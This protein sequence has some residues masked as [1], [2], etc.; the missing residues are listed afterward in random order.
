MLKRI[1]VLADI[2]KLEVK[3]SLAEI[4]PWLENLATIKG[5]FTKLEELLPEHLHE[6]DYLMTFGG[7]GLLLA[8]ARYVAGTKIP[9]IGVNFGRLGFLTEL[10]FAEFYNQIPRILEGQRIIAPR[11][12]LRCQVERHG[13]VVHSGLAV[14]DAVIKAASVARMTYTT[15]FIDEE[16]IT[17]YGGDGVIIATPVGSTAYSLSAG[18]PIVSPDIPALVITP[19]CPHV[20]TLRPLVISAQHRIRIQFLPATAEA[21][22]ISLD[23]QINWPLQLHDQLIITQAE[24]KFYLVETGGRSFYHILQEK[25]TW[26]HVKLNHKNTPT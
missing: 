2:R 1:A 19:I 13:T 11:M 12:M 4:Q 25:L 5:W 15:L 9:L 8:A 24:E 16:E 3:R 7:D 10:T 22:L 14:N 23:G 18:G 6:L 20:L 26:G 17:T 21:A